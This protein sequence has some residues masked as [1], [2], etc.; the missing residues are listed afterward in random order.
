MRDYLFNVVSAVVI[1]FFIMSL[2]VFL[3][4][5]SPLQASNDHFKGIHT[6]CLH[7]K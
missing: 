1:A 7:A 5:S 3:V 6:N 4:V 2:L